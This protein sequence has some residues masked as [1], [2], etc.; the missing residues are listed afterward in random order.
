M[1]SHQFCWSEIMEE[2]DS[3]SSD[4]NEE[5]DHEDVF[6]IQL[7]VLPLESSDILFTTK[8]SGFYK[9]VELCFSLIH[10]ALLKNQWDR[11]AELMMPYLQTLED[12][13]TDRQRRAPEIIWRL[14][15]EILLNHPKSSV[16]DVTLFNE[17]MKNIGVKNYL[18]ISLEQANFLLC[19]GQ[20]EDA[21]RIL[22][23]AG[24]WRYGRFSVSQDKLLKLIQAYRAQLDY[25]VWVDK[26]VPGT[27]EDPDYATHPDSIQEKNSYFR[28]ATTTFQEIIKFP[29]VW[30]PFV[31][32][33]IDLLESTGEHKEAKKV[34]SDYAY[35]SKY[36]KN[37]NAHMYLYQ[38]L[39]RNGASHRKLIKVLKVLHSLVPSHKLM[40]EFSSLLSQSESEKHHRLALNVLFDV[41]DFSGWKNDVEAWSCLAKRIKKTLKSNH[42][43]WVLEAWQGRKGWWPAY[44]FTKFHSK[45]EVKE[46]QK[47]AIKKALVSGILLGKDCEYFKIV[48]HLERKKKKVFRRIRKFVKKHTCA[49]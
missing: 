26:K 36:P 24:S 31:L 28:Q 43:S 30:D 49:G 14:G 35:N 32:S 48:C 3:H 7:P 16:E 18:K 38:F 1:A 4:E 9:T 42:S 23:V 15:N 33:Y 13:N 22:T 17:R 21:Y 46:N 29:G 39:K 37:P 41:L 12:N 45:K 8:F 27:E 11:A 25:L 6:G 34:L 44:H 20:K 19:N 10:E 40:L 2:S 5:L 47:L